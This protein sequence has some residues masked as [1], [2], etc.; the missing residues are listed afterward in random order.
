MTKL[1]SHLLI[2]WPMELFATSM[3]MKKIELISTSREANCKLSLY[4]FGSK[5]T[6]CT[7]C[8]TGRDVF[9]LENYTEVVELEIDLMLT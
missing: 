1:G 4:I 6:L 9:W 7:V 5:S 2:P 8:Q 3:S